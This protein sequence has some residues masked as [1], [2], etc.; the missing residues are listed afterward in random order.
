MSNI[1]GKGYE[2]SILELRSRRQLHSIVEERLTYLLR[3]VIPEE[4]FVPE[5]YGVPGGRHD[6]M[7]FSFNGRRIVFELFFSPSQVSQDLRL[8]E[9]ST[10]E[11]K[12]AILLDYEVD[13]RLS[14]E[15]FRKKPDS[16]PF[17][18]L[19]W[20]M[21][22]DFE[23][24]CIQRLREIIDDKAIINQLR[25]L[26][27]S[28]IGERIEKH[29]RK[30]LNEINRIFGAERKSTEPIK[31]LTP[32]KLAS[33]RIIGEF[34]KSGIPLEKLRSLYAWLLE[35]MPYAFT[36]VG[37]GFQAFLITDLNGR[38]AIWSDGDLADDLI[39]SP[40]VSKRPN[41]VLCLNDIINDIFEKVGFERREIQWHFF[42]TYLEF[43]ENDSVP[44]D[45]T[46]KM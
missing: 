21:E 9:Q 7:A 2:K 13:P 12:I 43:S 29:F 30:Q 35:A 42:H 36:I 6:L 3:K 38:H 33:L 32:T 8:L 17:I 39:L 45:I 37:S 20:V 10:A 5:I 34:R 23:K 16:F 25:Y 19:K 11:K 24:I 22:P 14:N 40:D 46:N 26:L 4:A 41:V 15:Y 44:F 31:D 18:W 28:P 1:D 27:E